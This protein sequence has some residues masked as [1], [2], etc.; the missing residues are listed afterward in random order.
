[1]KWA[2]FFFSV[3]PHRLATVLAHLKDLTNTAQDYSQEAFQLKVK[4]QEAQKVKTS[5]SSDI[6]FN[7][8]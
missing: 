1:M 5:L 7:Y 8:D 6:I 4:F 3:L 2:Y